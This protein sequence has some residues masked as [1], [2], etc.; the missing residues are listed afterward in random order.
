MVDLSL[1]YDNHHL[2]GGKN[3]LYSSKNYFNVL[4]FPQ[5]LSNFFHFSQGLQCYDEGRGFVICTHNTSQVHLHGGLRWP[6]SFSQADSGGLL[7]TLVFTHI[8]HFQKAQ[9]CVIEGSLEQANHHLKYSEPKYRRQ[10]LKCLP[11]FSSLEGEAAQ[12]KEV[13]YSGTTN[14]VLETE[15]R[16]NDM[17]RTRFHGLPKQDNIFT[18][19]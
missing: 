15:K 17:E 13:L 3:F 6:A 14:A 7:T 18:M 9:F 19:R 11:L 5:V 4:H 16:G 2:I 10:C 1:S 12:A 8:N